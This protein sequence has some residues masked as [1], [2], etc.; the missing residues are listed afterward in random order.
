MFTSCF[1]YTIDFRY[2][3]KPRG[4]I[5]KPSSVLGNC[6][7]FLDFL[8]VRQTNNENCLPLGDPCQS[9]LVGDAWDKGRTSTWR[10]AVKLVIKVIKGLPARTASTADSAPYSTSKTSVIFVT[11]GISAKMVPFFKAKLSDR[12]WRFFWLR[13]RVSLNNKTQRS[14]HE[15]W[16]VMCKNGFFRNRLTYP[17]A[18]KTRETCLSEYNG[19]RGKLFGDC[20][21]TLL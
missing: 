9:V 7:H 3:L 17:V 13:N 18:L 5:K 10:F 12:N 8:R 2:T 1:R 11:N 4:K 16:E 14:F 19:F 20:A 21:S 6:G 15:S